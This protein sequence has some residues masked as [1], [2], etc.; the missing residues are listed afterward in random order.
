[1]QCLIRTSC[2][3]PC[4]ARPM[5]VPVNKKGFVVFSDTQKPARTEKKEGDKHMQMRMNALDQ[6]RIVCKI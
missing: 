2:A 1:M 5:P 3:E 6:T 4:H